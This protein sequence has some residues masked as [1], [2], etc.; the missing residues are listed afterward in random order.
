VCGTMATRGRC[1][2]R[3]GGAGLIEGATRRGG[4]GVG[5]GI[6]VPT[7]ALVGGED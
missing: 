4:G 2:V 7:A 1:W 3:L 6:D 5:D